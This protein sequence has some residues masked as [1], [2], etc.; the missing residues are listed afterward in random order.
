[1]QATRM[2]EN[3]AVGPQLWPEQLG[4]LVAAGFRAVICNRP[5]GEEWGQPAFAEIAAAAKAAGLEAVY[6]PAGH[7]QMGP[8]LAA[9]FA[10]AVERLPKPVFAYCR[11]GARSAALWQ[12]AGA[13]RP[14]AA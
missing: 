11:S 1:M 12:I 2:S 9:E 8:R 4:E 3:L 13:G 5:D 7:S 14:R 6:V 10:D